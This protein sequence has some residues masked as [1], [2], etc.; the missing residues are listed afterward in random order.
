MKAI[1]NKPI[2]IGTGNC[3]ITTEDVE[4]LAHDLNQE[5]IEALT[6]IYP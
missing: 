2:I 6:R 3:S 1:K 5:S 4:N